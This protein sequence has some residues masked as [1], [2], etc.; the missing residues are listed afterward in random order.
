MRTTDHKPP[1]LVVLWVIVAVCVIGWIVLA[2]A[3]KTAGEG[4]MEHARE[5]ADRL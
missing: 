5:R 4:D 2:V 1:H 3:I